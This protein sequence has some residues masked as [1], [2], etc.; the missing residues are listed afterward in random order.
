MSVNSL[1]RLHFPAKIY[2][3]LE[4]GKLNFS[5]IFD[6]ISSSFAEYIVFWCTTIV[7]QSRLTSFDGK[8]EAGYSVSQIPSASNKKSSRSTSVVSASIR[9]N[10][11]MLHKKINVYLL[12]C[13]LACLLFCA[14][15]RQ[16]AVVRAATD[17]LVR[18]QV[19][20]SGGRQRLLP[21]P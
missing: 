14:L 6:I 16:S 15:R 19:Q 12:A 2:L 7:L 20:L 9:T 17:E 3:M 21:P 4:N 1:S 18:L 11:S 5:L 13:M 8:M 10:D